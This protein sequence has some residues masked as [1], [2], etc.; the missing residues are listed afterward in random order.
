MLF[1]GQG[2]KVSVAAQPKVQ[3]QEQVPEAPSGIS[4]PGLRAFE[5]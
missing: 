2:V 4:D 1:C 3:Q 5:S